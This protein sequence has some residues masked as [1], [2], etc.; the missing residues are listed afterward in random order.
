MTSPQVA[1]ILFST[2]QV[3]SHK[4]LLFGKCRQH[5]N[6]SYEFLMLLIINGLLHICELFIFILKFSKLL[7][8][9]TELTF[10]DQSGDRRYLYHQGNEQ[11]T[12]NTA[13]AAAKPWLIPA[14]K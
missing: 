3:C 5:I 13:E 9:N 6:I 4:R 12:G 10:W 14:G 7:M 8:K 1:S 2:G 11:T